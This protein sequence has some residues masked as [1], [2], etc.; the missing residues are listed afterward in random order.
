MKPYIVTFLGNKDVADRKTVYERILSQLETLFTDGVTAL[1][2]Y[3]VFYCGGYGEF[4]QLASMA[5]DVWRKRYPE[6]KSEKLFITPYITPSYLKINE[7]M[8]QFYDDIVYPPLE[9]VPFK[10]AISRRNQWMIDN[11]NMLIAYLENTAGNTRKCVEY[12][13]RRGKEVVFVDSGN[14]ARLLGFDRS[15]NRKRD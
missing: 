1:Y 12:A 14:A 5:I 11:C 8:R 10:F 15:K 13:F 3:P 7:Y 4:S 2:R 9:N 6:L